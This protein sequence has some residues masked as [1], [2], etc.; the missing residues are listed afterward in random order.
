MRRTGQ[1]FLPT[2][3]AAF[4]SSQLP[5]RSAFTTARNQNGSS[6]GAVPVNGNQSDQLAGYIQHCLST[7]STHLGSAASMPSQESTDNI[8][9]SMSGSETETEAGVEALRETIAAISRSH[10]ELQIEI[11][12]I[13]DKLSTFATDA[14][15]VPKRPRS[16]IASQG[17]S[18]AK[19]SATAAVEEEENAQT[20]VNCVL[21]HP[22]AL[23]CTRTTCSTDT[24]HGS[25]TL[26]LRTT[27]RVTE[28]AAVRGLIS[29]EELA[30]LAGQA[31]L[32][33]AAEHLRSQIGS[34]QFQS[35]REPDR[36]R[37]K[38]LG[39]VLQSGDVIEARRNPVVSQFGHESFVMTL[40]DDASGRCLKA[41]FKPRVQGDADGW[42]NAPMEWVAYRLNLLL[43]LDYVP[44]V[45]YR[46]NG[47]SFRVGDEE[48]SYPEGAMMYFVEESRPL[49]GF[50]EAQWGISKSVLLSDTRILD[51]LLHNSDR[52]HGHFLLGKHWCRGTT[53]VGNGEWRGERR[54]CLIDHAASFRADADVC[55]THE[56]AFQTGPVRCVS[57]RTY[58]RLRFLDYATLA[59]EFGDM[60]TEDQLRGMSRRRDAVLRYLD[61]LVAQQGYA[62]TVIE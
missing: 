35:L 24:D 4:R 3:R 50:P 27:A 48:C 19:A 47:I 44:P 39:R 30:A 29:P 40:R 51:V 14:E 13:V 61:G 8:T 46:K 33:G 32:G 23:C 9:S 52:H 15:A 12:R 36:Q 57:A 55:M 42:H 60:L 45:A 28:D 37:H 31:L 26:I 2:P 49:R 5:I 21:Q 20:R 41:I 59:A 38:E 17:Q 25:V 22:G 54:P 11:E 34:L 56:N 16:Q 43:G 58:L 18:S 1:G 7:A 62:A 10:R 53:Q 6:N